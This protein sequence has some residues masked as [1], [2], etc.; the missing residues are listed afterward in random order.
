M[1]PFWNMY[2]SLSSLLSHFLRKMDPA[3]LGDLA[4]NLLEAGPFSKAS[5]IPAFLDPFLT[6]PGLDRRVPFLWLLVRTP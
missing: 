5:V 2:K 1:I 4:L 6:M 3:G